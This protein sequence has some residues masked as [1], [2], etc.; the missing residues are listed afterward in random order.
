MR[1]DPNGTFAISTLLIGLLIG[2]IAGT[3]T[4]IA[5]S[6][7]VSA[8]NTSQSL[9]LSPLETAWYT[10]TGLFAGNYW[11][12][13]DHWDTVSQTIQMDKQDR[14]KFRF[15][16]NPYYSLWTSS[17][18]SKYIK[19]NFYADVPSRTNL[20]LD[21]EL[22]LHYIAYLFGNSHAKDGSDMNVPV[23]N[24]DP[25]AVISESI[26]VWLRWKFRLNIFN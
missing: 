12:V 21:I 16:K 7:A 14:Y 6:G 19:A 5:V 20:G 4:Y 9:G 23:W 22:R 10:F 13:L 18:Y 3:A 2:A 1:V 26:A 15:D 17:L 11:V 24:I 8:Y 25:T